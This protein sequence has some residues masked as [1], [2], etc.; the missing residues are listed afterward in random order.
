MLGGIEGTNIDKSAQ[1]EVSVPFLFLRSDILCTFPF[2]TNHPIKHSSKE[3]SSSDLSLVLNYRDIHGGDFFVKEDVVEKETDEVSVPRHGCIFW[4]NYL[5]CT[6]ALKYELPRSRANDASAA[7]DVSANAIAVVAVDADGRD[8][9]GVDVD[10]DLDGGVDGVDVGGNVH[11]DGSGDD[12][13]DVDDAVRSMSLADRDEADEASGAGVDP[14]APTRACACATRAC[15]A[16]DCACDAPTPTPREPTQFGVTGDTGDTAPAA[17]AAADD[18][19]APADAI[20]TIPT[21]DANPTPTAK[22]A[23]AKATAPTAPAREST[24]HAP[25]P[26][27]GSEPSAAARVPS[28]DQSNNPRVQSNADSDVTR[29]HQSDVTSNAPADASDASATSPSRASRDRDA[30]APPR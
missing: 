1:N 17:P 8:V 20:P 12:V 5:S 22:T 4:K 7:N 3:E 18:A 16:C 29:D 28:G 9:D 14:V 13:D 11:V 26:S 23:P 24:A 6:H 30:S 25:T 2:L 15:A 19:A 21:A 10:W 27:D